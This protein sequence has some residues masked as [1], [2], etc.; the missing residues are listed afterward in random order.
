MAD[1]KNMNHPGKIT[2]VDGA[3]ETVEDA[4]ALPDSFK[5]AENRHGKKMPVV[6]VVAYTEGDRRIIREY[7]PEGALLRSTVQVR[8]P[9]K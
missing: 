6:R 8:A 9:A 3:T 2:F 7:G 4:A 1:T 5:F